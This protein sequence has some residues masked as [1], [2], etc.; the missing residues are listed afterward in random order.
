MSLNESLEE[1]FAMVNRSAQGLRTKWVRFM[2]IGLRVAVL[3]I[4][5]IAF[6]TPARGDV[7]AISSSDGATKTVFTNSRR[8]PAGSWGGEH[9]LLTVTDKGATF[10]IDCAHG[11][12]DEPLALDANSRFSARGVYIRE[13]G[14]PEREGQRPDSHPARYTGWSDGK[15][16][17]LTITLTDADQTIGEFNLALGRDPQMTKCL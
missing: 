2:S 4:G 14:G 1:C 15:T 16:M 13:R 17:T 11:T 9:I 12:I 5:G 10:E 6:I 3:I 8:V 7:V